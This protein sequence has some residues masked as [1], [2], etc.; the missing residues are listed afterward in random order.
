MLYPVR[1]SPCKNGLRNAALAL[2]IL[3]SSV[4]HL[5]AH[6]SSGQE[7]V[8]RLG[9]ELAAVTNGAKLTFGEL[10]A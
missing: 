3:F 6:P 1:S 7:P 10:D 2:T 8:E 4:P 9:I 5:S